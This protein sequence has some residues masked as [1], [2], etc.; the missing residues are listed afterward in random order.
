LKDVVITNL[1]NVVKS[2]LY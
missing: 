1:I 2:R